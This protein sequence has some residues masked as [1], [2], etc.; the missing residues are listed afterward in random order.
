MAIISANGQLQPPVSPGE[1]IQHKKWDMSHVTI[2]KLE[3]NL[4][5]KMDGFPLHHLLNWH[6]YYN[7]LLSASSGE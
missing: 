5:L 4:V 2:L 1:N 6:K 7:Y 3:V